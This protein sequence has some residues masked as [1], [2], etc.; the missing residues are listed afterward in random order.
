MRATLTT[1][2]YCGTGCNFYLLSD[3]KGRLTGIEPA[4]KHSTSRGQLCLKGWNAH[5]FVHHPERLTTPQIRID[6]RLQSCSWEQ[7]L[8]ETHMQL[9]RIAENH[10]PDS[11][12]FL[13]SAKVSNEENFLMMKLARA[14]FGT[15]N[16][17]HCARLCH[18]ST[19][20]GL[21]ETLGSGAM[22]NSLS[23]FNQTDLVFVIGSNTTEQHPLIGSR[24]LQAQ[25]RGAGL[26]VADS[27][28]IQ[29]AE[30][31]NLHLRHHNGTDV[32]LINGMMRQILLDG[33]EDRNFIDK[34]TENFAALR[35]SL[36]A[37][38]P[39]YVAGITGLKEHEITAA[40]RLYAQ[41]EKVMIVFAMGIT[42]H[43]H[44]VDNV[45]ALSNL[46][47]MT[48]NLGRPGTGINP[49]RGQNNVQ[50]ACDMGALPDVYS[51]Y[52]RVA[53]ARTRLKFSAAWKKSLPEKPGLMATHAIEAAAAGQIRGMLIMGEN[54]MLSEPNQKHVRMALK[55]LEFLAVID[56]FPTETAQLADLVLPAACYAERDGTYTSTERR[57]QRG[58]KAVAPPGAAR[59]DWQILGD[60]LR[61]CGVPADY[62]SPAEIMEEIARLTPSY[63]GA[64]YARLEQGE[65]LQWPCPE[66]EHPG[67]AIL[68]RDQCTRGKGR[69]S[70]TRYRPPQELPDEHYPFL[71]NTG[72]TAVHWHT[73]S[74]TRRS[75][76]L[77]REE[78]QAY[79]EIHPQD[80]QKLNI[81]ERQMLRI[82]SRR[83]TI[84]VSAR[85]T[86]RVP[87]GQIFIPFH[88]AEG[89]ANVLT[90][91][92][93]DPESGIPEFKVCAV[94]VEL[95]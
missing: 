21:V 49:L 13:S 16:I 7:A 92:A 83:G 59:A 82:S 65:S 78:P 42:Q 58:R 36:E 46:A 6:G 86:E 28:K 11:L 3:D 10:G 41:A 51:G 95:C 66:P 73:G 30:H 34:R 85:L 24:I 39:Q 47:L 50:G 55:N 33:L 67:T 23:C 38:T 15:N 91:N 2:P 27:R 74:M 90:N 14:G 68:H 53:D 72:R 43:T 52:Q 25:Q 45:R 54:P 69:F 63:G 76:L 48:G 93:L 29:L 1:C 31:A 12:M 17:D 94:R 62:S 9:K 4:G 75:H 70:P 77:E 57:I 35:D 8:A 37:F 84:E 26:I 89:A 56:I 80:A 60:L 18:S 44:G 79:T 87:P 32:A 61:R 81:S 22:T 64:T 71:L 88:Y 40:A 19:V 20:T 5:A